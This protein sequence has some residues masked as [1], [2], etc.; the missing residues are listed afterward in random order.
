MKSII[1]LSLA[2]LCT[3]QAQSADFK[4]GTLVKKIAFGAVQDH[5]GDTSHWKAVNTEL[6][7]IWVWLGEITETTFAGPKAK[8]KAY[9]KVLATLGYQELRARS[10]ILG[11]WDEEDARPS[12]K[13]NS[14][15]FLEFIGEAFDSP[16]FMRNALYA[17]YLIGPAGKQI[18][19][20]LLDTFTQRKK[21]KDLLGSQ[22][23]EWLEKELADEVDKPSVILIGSPLP[24]LGDG[25]RNRAW[26]D[27][28]GE[29]LKLMNLLSK[30]NTP[31][32][33]LSGHNRYGEFSQ[34]E[35]A[36]GLKLVEVSSSGLNKT[37]NK[38]KDNAFRIGSPVLGR[39]FGILEFQ[40]PSSE[41]SEPLKTTYR[42]QNL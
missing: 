10:Q 38:S 34:V 27:Y 40:W 18:K 30:I 20:I 14:A 39:N 37:A 29:Q 25:D 12:R 26:R 1:I 15:P 4:Y 9:D 7:N 32:Y 19:L 13:K 5:K 16:R 8:K 17:S 3:D 28:S 42:I 36:N 41:N 22:Q 33:I 11:V 35:L 6:P 21:G 2:F 23:W 24:Y 31:T